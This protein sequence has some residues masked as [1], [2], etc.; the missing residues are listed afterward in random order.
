MP[1]SSASTHPSQSVSVSHGQSVQSRRTKD[2]RYASRAPGGKS[3]APGASKN[4]AASRAHGHTAAVG[5]GKEHAAVVVRDA[6]GM[7]I[8]PKSLLTKP[9]GAPQNLVGGGGTQHSMV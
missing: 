1:E 4:A 6:D 5:R 7:D 9:G 2:S 8:T 3:R